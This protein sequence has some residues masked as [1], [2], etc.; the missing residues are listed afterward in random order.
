MTPVL[1]ITGP[2]ATGKSALAVHLARQLR[3]EVVNADSQ[4]VYRG[5]DI[6]T[7]KLPPAQ[8]GGI[9]HH[10]LDVVEPT[11][12]YNAAQYAA[13]ATAAILGIQIRG[14]VS[15]V[16]GGT[17]LYLKS[18]VWGLC[19]APPADPDTRRTLEA[20]LVAHGAAALHAE[21]AAV[22][23]ELAAQIHPHHTSRVLR[24]LEVWQL[25]GRSLRELQRAPS[26]HEPIPAVWVGLTCDRAA[27]RERIAAR[28]AD[29]L[30]AGWLDEVRA[31][32]ARHGPDAPAL[33]A[34]GYRELAA[35][36]Q[37]GGDCGAVAAQI[38]TATAQYAKRQMTY[39]RKIR[40]ITWFDV[41]QP[42]WESAVH[43]LSSTALNSK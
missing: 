31:L 23:P 32:V 16:V 3:G 34:I 35:H 39:L 37:H 18:L 4:A 9:T 6:G 17:G 36:L 12:Q 25:A 33:R 1:I 5:C 38:I 29:Q 11:A 19:E 28:V 13:A 10:L 42:E 41:T 20:R 15:I 30:A 2:T 27:L 7:G 43:R 21:L 8:R 22:D 24:A 40:E 14:H 26:A